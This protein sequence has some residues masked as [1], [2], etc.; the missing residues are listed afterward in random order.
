[1]TRMQRMDAM[2]LPFNVITGFLG[3]G[4]TTLLN[5]LLKHPGMDGTF[6]IVNEFGDIGIDHLLV[7]ASPG[8]VIELASGCLCCALRGDLVETLIRVLQERAEGKIKAF[9]R[10]V[11]E[12][13]GLADP[14]P[15]LHSIM[16]HSWLMR[17]LRLDGVAAVVDAIAGLDTLSRHEEAVKQAAMA[18]RLVIAKTDMAE[19]S[20]E[21]LADLEAALRGINPGAEILHSGREVPG[22]EDIFAAGLMDDAGRARL[23]RWLGRLASD[24]PGARHH[25]HDHAAHTSGIDSFA[26]VHE[27]AISASGLD[28]F[29][30]LLRAN[31]GASLLRVKGVV[32]LADDES[33][34]MVIHGVQ[35]IFHPPARLPGW[36]DGE[37][38]TRIVFITRGNVREGIE[39]LFAA[40]SDPL[41]GMGAAAADDTLSLLPGGDG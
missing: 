31:F 23:G 30:D 16:G 3:A 15:I 17:H 10:I 5:H 39:K 21:T 9:S 29:I 12:T 35:H 37:E 26:I 40:V 41:G 28:V 24:A 2:P 1:M 34:P 32:R 27:G 13:S 38:A 33:R 14:A 6:V 11:V 20:P 4:K 8:E 19:A 7:E 36:P 18:E 22:P 25:G